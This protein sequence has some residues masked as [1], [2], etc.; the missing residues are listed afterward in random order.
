MTYLLNFFFINKS[1]Y[2]KKIIICFSLFLGMGI[3]GIS[4]VG[5]KSDNTAPDPSSMLD[6]FSPGK[7]LLIPR[8]ALTG[9]T[10]T[11][12][13]PVPATS[14]LVFNTA[15]SG[16]FP[17]NVTP[18]YYYWNCNSWSRFD[19]SGATNYLTRWTS[20]YTQGNSMLYDNGSKIGIGTTSPT[21]L[22]HGVVATDSATLILNSTAIPSGTTY[23]TLDQMD[24]KWSGNTDYARSALRYNI[25]NTH[26]EY[27]QVF[28]TPIL[29]NQNTINVDLASQKFELR[30]GIKDMEFKNMG[31]TFFTQA[32]SVGIATTNIPP[33]VKFRVNGKIKCGEFEIIMVKRPIAET[34]T[35][36]LNSGQMQQKIVEKMNEKMQEIIALNKLLREQKKEIE[37]LRKDIASLKKDN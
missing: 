22:I 17:N 10:D 27:S 20:S 28:Y 26:P 23:Y 15:A 18:G 2:M 29:L 4:Q 3:S 37:S 13:I 19:G 8:V 7:G 31:S 16:M 34:A 36:G 32:G 14:L 9:T 11:T 6:V 24:V 25:T 5:I 30:S 35:N 1:S 21:A 33:G 12:T